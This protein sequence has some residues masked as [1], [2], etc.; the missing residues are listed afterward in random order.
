MGTLHIIS[1]T[2]KTWKTD[3]KRFKC[4]IVE[5]FLLH[6]YEAGGQGIQYEQKCTHHT[7]L[8]KTVSIELNL[9][10]NRKGKQILDAWHVMCMCLCM[11]ANKGLGW[12]DLPSRGLS[13]KLSR[14]VFL[15]PHSE[16]L[17]R[18]PVSLH[19]PAN[20]RTHNASY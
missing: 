8:K 17:R 4:K 3:I 20:P 1:K 12:T 19:G 7:M 2:V 5:K 6:I 9:P 10:E 18:P 11:S 15:L 14:L 13:V 16:T